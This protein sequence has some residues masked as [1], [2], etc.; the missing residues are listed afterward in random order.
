MQAALLFQRFVDDE[1]ALAPALVQR[2]LA[3]TLQLLGQSRDA[4]GAAERA[5][6]GDI[7]KALQRDAAAFEKSFVDAL[8]RRVRDA[9]DELR[10]SASVEPPTGFGSLELMDE[11]RVEVDIELSRAMQLID[12]TAEWELRE[13]QTFT[14]TLTGHRHVNAE[15]NPFRPIVYASALWDAASVVVTSPTQRVIVLRTAAGVVAGLLR[16]AWAT[17]STRLESQGVRPGV[18]RTVVLPSGASYGRFT[19]P[20][21]PRSRGLGSLLASMPVEVGDRASVTQPGVRSDGGSRHP[22]PALDDALSQLDTRLRHVPSD[23]SLA[24]RRATPDD[25]LAQHRAALV[26]TA[27]DTAERQLI[28]LVTRLF[29]AMLGD[30]HVPAPFRPVIARMQIP[31]LRTVLADPASIEQEEHP[32]WRL[33]NRIGEASLGQSRT[34]DPRLSAFLSYATAVAEEMAGATSPD[35]ILFRRGL[36]R[37]DVFLAEQLQAQ[38]RA[39]HGAVEA[40][41]VA[42]RREIL[43]Q[44]LSQR[45]SEQMV[46]IRTSPVIRRFVTGTWARVIAEDMLRHGDQSEQTLSDLKTVD[47]LLWSLKIPDHPQSRQRLLQLLPTLLHRVRVGMELVALPMAEQQAVLDELMGNHTE[48]LRPG[49]RAKPAHAALT[50]EEIVQRMRDEVVSDTPLHRSFGDSVIDL[51]SMETVPAEHL[52]SRGGEQAAD[53]AGARIEALR[54]GNRQRVFLQGRWSRTQLLWRSDRSLFFV[55]AGDSPSRTHSITRRALERLSAAGLVQPIESS[56]LI[57]RAVDRLAR[58]LGSRPAA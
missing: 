18:F 5:Q 44:H 38:V 19:G 13:L 16:S 32:L 14:S 20:E 8:G 21:A 55:F 41:K 46:S 11:S 3:G 26:A 42:E 4:V 24:G 53:D 29:E 31:A 48:A 1:L 52:P 6:Y 57:G 25:G 33:L 51:S 36:N 17:A 49:P 39:A 10:E 28:E 58:E 12:S 40:L 15:S 54:A 43:E 45:L 56:S 30:A 27:R 35:A 7:V 50:P 22:N 2:V 34:E 9:I 47:D 23:P 37:I